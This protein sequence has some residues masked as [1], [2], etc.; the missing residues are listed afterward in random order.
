MLV[1]VVVVVPVV[2]V[3]RAV[4]LHASLVQQSLKLRIDGPARESLQV[5]SFDVFLI[6][7]IM[8]KSNLHLKGLE[9]LELIELDNLRMSDLGLVTIRVHT[10]GS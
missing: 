8:L 10:D 7:Q 4:G 9:L 6:S 2:A 5:L 1:L 3:L